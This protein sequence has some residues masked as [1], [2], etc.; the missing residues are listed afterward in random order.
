MC[1]REEKIKHMIFHKEYV[2]D[3]QDDQ[4]RRDHNKRCSEQYNSATK[5]AQS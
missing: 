3:T 5:Q 2:E 4:Q 1:R